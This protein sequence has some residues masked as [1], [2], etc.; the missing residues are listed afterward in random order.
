MLTIKL[1]YILFILIFLF[2]SCSNNPEL[3]DNDE[4]AKNALIGVWR[5]TGEYGEGED[6]GWDETW[7]IVRHKDG[8]FEVNYLLIHDGNKEYEYTKDSGLWKFENGKYYEIYE[9]NLKSVYKV[10]SLKKD[11]FEY[12]QIERSDEV[13]IKEVKTEDTFQLQGPPQGY[14]EV[15]RPEPE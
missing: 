4:K 14:I 1:K 13:T 9:D 5:G 2:L 7:K 15:V 12:N 3:M 8:T 6:Q 10:Y 11:W